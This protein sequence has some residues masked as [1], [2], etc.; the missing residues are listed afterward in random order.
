M[1]ILDD[2]LTIVY[3]PK[4]IDPNEICIDADEEEEVS[5]TKEH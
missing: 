1:A 5:L 3:G 2:E 4:K